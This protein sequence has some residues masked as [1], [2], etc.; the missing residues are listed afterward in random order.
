MLLRSCLL[1]LGALVV[2]GC[3][4]SES[5]LKRYGDGLERLPGVTTLDIGVSTPLPWAVQGTLRVQLAPHVTREQFDAF[6]RKACDDDVNAS[7]SFVFTIDVSD[8]SSIQ[9]RIPGRCS[10]LPARIV[11]LA[12]A[13]RGHVDGIDGIEWRER[14][15]GDSEEHTAGL[16]LGRGG[17]VARIVDLAGVA[18]DT[19]D[20]PPAT[21]DLRGTGVTITPTTVARAR[22]VLAVARDLIDAGHPVT[23][24]DA[25][26]DGVLVQ[27]GGG[28]DVAAAEALARTASPDLDVRVIDDSVDV[29]GAGASDDAIDLA[30]AL[31]A[32]DPTWEAAATA[33]G[34]RV[35][36]STSADVLR[37]YA[38][39]RAARLADTRI[40]YA[41]S[42]AAGVSVSIATSRAALTRP[43]LEARVAV[44]DDLVPGLHIDTLRF[45]RGGVQAWL[46]EAHYDDTRSVE[47]ARDALRASLAK[48]GLDRIAFVTLNN[49]DVR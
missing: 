20:E 38:A 8:S 42:P 21:F 11:E 1:L 44:I 45:E 10:Q 12:P 46:D 27:L 6:A 30:A 47:A 22:E 40:S 43:E 25:Q 16:Q 28:G 13:L 9:Q 4:Q 19:L 7:V 35:E 29:Q 26:K 34:V 32:E 36:V 41:V 17:D 23:K 37:A 48:H 2:A 39:A 3:G 31:E 49:R 15:Q 24:V 33:V 14:R 18:L 5:D